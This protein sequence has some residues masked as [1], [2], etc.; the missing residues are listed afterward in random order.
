[1]RDDADASADAVTLDDPTEPWGAPPAGDDDTGPFEWPEPEPFV[2]ESAPVAAPTGAEA[3]EP[4]PAAAEPEPVLPEAAPFPAPV[5]S[6]PRP[7]RLRR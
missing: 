2:V 5:A 4:E 1:Q 6:D 3:A 7:P